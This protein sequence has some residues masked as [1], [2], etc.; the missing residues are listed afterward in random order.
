M[1][2]KSRTD[3]KLKELP[4]EAAGLSVVLTVL[5]ICKI[6][7][8]NLIRRKNSK[9][10]EEIDWKKKKQANKEKRKKK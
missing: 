8:Q 1:L 4:E 9:N 10:G 7:K 6:R 3:N 5:Y 2:N